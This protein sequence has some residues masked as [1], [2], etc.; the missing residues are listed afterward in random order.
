MRLLVELGANIVSICFGFVSLHI[1]SSDQ[2]TTVQLEW[3][4]ENVL[5]NLNKNELTQVISYLSRNQHTWYHRFVKKFP[6]FIPC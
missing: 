6:Q 1:F 2:S 5:F 4:I 3:V